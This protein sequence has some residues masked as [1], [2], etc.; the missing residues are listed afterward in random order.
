VPGSTHLEE[1]EDDNLVE[2]PDNESLDE[3][4]NRDNW[5]VVSMKDDFNTIFDPIPPSRT[6]PMCPEF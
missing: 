5:I 6:P 2:V 1:D 4:Q 3:A